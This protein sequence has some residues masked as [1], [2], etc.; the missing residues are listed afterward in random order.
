MEQFVNA[1]HDAAIPGVKALTAKQSTR[2]CRNV[3]RNLMDSA[4]ATSEASYIR[5]RSLLRAK[6]A[7]A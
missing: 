4:Q 7:R 1:A 2:E 6:Y 5:R 3:T